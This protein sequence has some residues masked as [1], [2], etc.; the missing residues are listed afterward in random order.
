MTRQASSEPRPK[1]SLG[2]H[3]L[4]D[5]SYLERMLLAAD[6]GEGDRVLE[7]GPGTGV[8]TAALAA[9]GAEVIA[10]ELDD[11]LAERLSEQYEHVPNVDVVH[12]D[13][14]EIDIASLVG[15][16]ASNND[17]REHLSD[18]KPRYKVVANL[19]YYITSAILRR[20]L[21][22]NPPPAIATI[23]VQKEVAERICAEPG[24]MSLLA[25]SVQYYAAPQFVAVVPAGAFYPRPKVDSAIVRLDVHAQPAIDDVQTDRY[26]AVVRAGFAQR[27]K[28]VANSLSAGLA[29][30][31]QQVRD[32]LAR[33]GIDARRRAETFSLQEWRTICIA[34]GRA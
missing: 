16:D 22:A 17:S 26:F 10:V 6:I 24:D 33:A 19:P 18:Y 4:R 34:L 15:A 30:P 23:M 7:I 8:L 9:S 25:V 20:L 14:L 2:Q 31:K 1:R 32:A 5:K 28:Q 21:E 29:M 13:I 11:L 3:F 27:R 12:G